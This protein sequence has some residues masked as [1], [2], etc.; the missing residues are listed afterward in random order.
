MSSVG[1]LEA[2]WPH[3]EPAAPNPDTERIE[4]RAPLTR[5]SYIEQARTT[6]ATELGNSPD[7]WRMLIADD[8]EQ[9]TESLESVLTGEPL[10]TVNTL[11]STTDRVRAERAGGGWILSG[12]NRR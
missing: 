10:A 7:L 12:C 5:H 4:L 6:S 9:V 8:P 11:D 3:T 1:T 2:P